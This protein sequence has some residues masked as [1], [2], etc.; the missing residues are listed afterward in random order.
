MANN[1][2]LKADLSL[3]AAAALEGLAQRNGGSLAEALSRA[4]GTETYLLKKRK[5][6]GTVIIEEP[7]GQ[8][9]EVVFPH[10]PR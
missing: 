2:R 1:V 10:L 7:D 3:A 8:W 9:K 6:S 4:I 5:Q